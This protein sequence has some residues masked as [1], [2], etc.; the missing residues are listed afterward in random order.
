MKAIRLIFAIAVLGSTATG[1]QAL[2][3][4]FGSTVAVENDIVFV[5]KARTG[6][7]AGT[8]YVYGREH[9]IGTWAER[10]RLQASDAA[11]QSDHFGRAMAADGNTLFVGA[12]GSDE[13]RGAVYVF[14]LVDGAWVESAKLTARDAAE[15]HRFGNALAVLGHRLLV[16]AVGPSEKEGAVYVFEFDAKTGAWSE[17]SILRRTDGEPDE[18]PDDEAAPTRF[19]RM[20]GV[21]VAGFGAALALG[22]HTAVISAPAHGGNVLVYLHD[23]ASDTWSMTGELTIDGLEARD[24]FGYALAVQDSEVFVSAPR[25][26]NNQGAIFTFKQDSATGQWEQ[27]GRLSGFADTPGLQ[28]LG[29]TLALDGTNLWAGAPMQNRSVGMVLRYRRSA[30]TDQW[31]S[32]TQVFPNDA[33]ADPSTSLALGRALGVKGL[34]AVIG[35]PGADNGAGKAYVFENT[36]GQWIEAGAFIDEAE[37]IPSIVGA[38]VKCTDG[39]ADRFG[40]S[41]VD[42]VSFLSVADLGGGRGVEVNDLWGW[43]DPETGREWALIGRIDGTSMVDVTD[44]Y[45][46][47]Y[48]GNLPKTAASPASTW[49]DI[50]VYKDHAFIVADGA[51][52]HG[53]QVFDLRQL[54]DVQSPPVTFEISAHYTDIASAHNIVINEDTGFAFAVG[55]SGGGETC[56]GGLHMIDI[57]EPLQPTFAGCFADTETGRRGTGYSH[58]AQCVIYDGPDTEHR[59]REICFGANETALSISDVSDKDSPVKLSN[60]TYPNYGYSHQ[61]WLTEDHRYFYMNDELDELQGSVDGTRTMIWDVSDLD[62]PQLAK[63]HLS[64]NKASDHNLY[65]QDDL[66]YQSNYQSGLRVLDI[67]DR[68]NPAEVGFFDTVPYGENAPSFGGS[69]SNY[70]FFKSGII[71]VTSGNE[72]MFIVKKR[73]VDT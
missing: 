27:R 24:T 38:E 37:N 59:S 2:Q 45:N 8:V 56:G 7:S 49:R 17:H 69:W 61:G 30:E 16:T 47:L 34:T 19:W 6:T 72:G 31:I 52:D 51:R 68:E 15:N 67:S 32:V 12:I 21:P 23:P 73:D 58:D 53:M 70:P 66:M 33:L 65:I 63:E 36:D 57:T 3:T 39:E 14:T 40:C 10:Q 11:G 50:K 42:L 60:A 44:P 5:G 4:G 25:L 20:G 13:S 48:V 54:R 71:V 62:D 35:A 9:T 43:T 55:S 29:S 28:M 41:N 1:V 22:E 46:P 26:D 18:E 64:E